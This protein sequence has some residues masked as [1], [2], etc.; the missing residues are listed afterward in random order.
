MAQQTAIEWFVDYLEE[1]LLAYD[2]KLN[3]KQTEAYDM[4]KAMEK[5][6]IIKSFNQGYREGELDNGNQLYPQ[7]DISEYCDAEQYYKEKFNK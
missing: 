6:Q 3:L 4:A 2:M 5:E 7:K 1:H